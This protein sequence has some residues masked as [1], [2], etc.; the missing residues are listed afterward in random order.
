MSVQTSPSV[1]DIRHALKPLLVAAWAWWGGW[2]FP[3]SRRVPPPPGFQKP[4]GSPRSTCAFMPVPAALA[5]HQ[6]VCLSE[7]GPTQGHCTP[8]AWYVS[9]Y[10]RPAPCRAPANLQGVASARRSAKTAAGAQ[11][12]G[13]ALINKARPAGNAPVMWCVTRGGATLKPLPCFSFLFTFTQYLCRF[14]VETSEHSQS[15]LPSLNS[16]LEPEIPYNSQPEKCVYITRLY[17]PQAYRIVIIK[18]MSPYYHLY[19]K[20]QKY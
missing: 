10:L 11:E 1:N 16:S 15:L 7:R 19:D 17:T 12:R 8:A 13:S 4:P 2:R 5:E 9:V 6:V 20:K 3:A 18:A 14:L